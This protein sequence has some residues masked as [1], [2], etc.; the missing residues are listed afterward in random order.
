MLDQII[1]FVGAAIGIAITVLVVAGQIARRRLAARTRPA[2]QLVD[3]DGRLVHVETY[4]RSGP[5]VVL[6]G[7]TWTPGAYWRPIAAALAPN[8]LV[9]TYDRAGLGHSETSRARR[10]ASVMADELHATLRAAG[11]PAPYVLVGHSFGGT[12]VRTFASRHP[13]ETAG[14]VLVDASHEEQFELAP[15][16]IRAFQHR[17]ASM[18]RPMFFVVRIAAR[19]GILALRPSLV[20]LA[21][22]GTPADVADELRRVVATR[23]GVVATMAREMLDLDASNAALR[24]AGITSLGDLPLVVLSHSRAEGTP[25]QLGPEVAS[26]YEAVWQELQVRQAALSTRGRRVVVDGAGHDIPSERPDVVVVAIREVLADADSRPRDVA[27]SDRTMAP[28]D[29]DPRGGHGDPDGIEPVTT[30]TNRRHEP[31]QQITRIGRYVAALALATAL[32]TTIA[33]CAGTA[34]G[35]NPT[36]GAPSVDATR[37]TEI[38][39]VAFPALNSGD[40]AAW[41]A[42]WSDAM[43]GAIGPDAFEQFRSGVIANLGGYVSHGKPT[44]SSVKSGT[45]RWTF[46]V[47][48]EKGTGAIAFAFFDGSSV[49]DGIHVE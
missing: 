4:G 14:L 42:A 46:E 24:S 7:G 16:P 36:P 34:D 22:A 5:T 19:A 23:S 47:T 30:G 20:P 6:E 29:L 13:A 2:G 27:V 21:S 17:M 25:P 9:V 28:R 18:M 8:A 33:A 41:T 32:A 12:I 10:T 40:Y 35:A 3:V 38:A 37:V 26:A 15:E 45:Y 1:S 48:F 44:L 31:M 39:D 49:V 43:K 11:A